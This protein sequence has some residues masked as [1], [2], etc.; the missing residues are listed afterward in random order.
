VN[1]AQPTAQPVS[2]LKPVTLAFISLGV[3]ALIWGYSWPVMKVGM[4]Y[5]QPF[6]F[7]ALRAFVGAILMIAILPLARRPLRPTAVAWTALLGLFQ[8]TGFLG[9]TMWALENGGA[10]KTSVLVYTMPFWL[11]LMAWTFL[12]ERLRGA[13]WAAV[14]L[15]LAGLVLVLSPWRLHGIASSLMAV[16]AGFSW[17]AS[18]IVMKMMRRRFKVDALSVTSW[19]M[20]FG[21]LPLVLIG[22]L[23]ATRSPIWT[24]SFIAVFVYMV[25]P[26]SGVAWLLWAY[27]TKSLP[28]G[29]VGVGSLIIPVIGVASSW[30]Q[31][32]ERPGVAEAIGIPLIVVAL[33][34]VSLRDIIGGRR[35]TAPAI[36]HQE[37]TP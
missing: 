33:A 34:I 30:I 27:I 28:T 24:G 1:T 31:L 10:G 14:G 12:Q 22:V 29:T 23:T 15:A 36:G 5:T 37:A 8:T 18:C 20:L 7:A 19:Q 3:L 25:I 6:T 35:A 4:Q 17:A 26:A 21:S 2:R 16:G 13:Q 32:G 9:F 11:L